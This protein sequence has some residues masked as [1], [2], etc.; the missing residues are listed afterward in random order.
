M[1]DENAPI[2]TLRQTRAISAAEREAMQDRC[3]ELALSQADC[4]FCRHVTR[5]FEYGLWLLLMVTLGAV[6]RLRASDPALAVL[7]ALA[8]F[9]LPLLVVA[10]RWRGRQ[11]QRQF[12]ARD[13]AAGDSYTLDAAGLQRQQGNVTF[14]FPWAAIEAM[15]QDTD[16]L[17]AHVAPNYSLQL[18]KAAFAG[19]GV[20]AFCAELMHRWHTGCAAAKGAES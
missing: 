18:A 20:E 11:L 10:G 2:R 17:V 8:G 7:L 4:R 9:G 15:A 13:A 5:L 16:Y 1:P 3:R 14:R 19:Q 6:D 12:E